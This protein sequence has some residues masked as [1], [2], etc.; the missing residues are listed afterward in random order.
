MKKNRKPP[1]S[2]GVDGEGQGRKS[3]RY[4]ML[5]YSDASG[6]RS[7][8]VEAKEGLSTVQC[9]DF[10]LS[11]P[12]SARAFAFAFNYDLTKILA[13]VPDRELYFL[14][15]PELRVRPLHPDW[16]PAPV[17]YFPDPEDH[18]CGYS[19][20]LQGTKF[21]VRRTRNAECKNPRSRTVWDV[22]RFFQ[23]SFVSALE[24]WKVGTDESRARMLRMKD[25]RKDFDKLPL[26]EIRPYCL[27]ECRDMATLA[28][29]LISAHAEAGIELK[30]FYGA[31]TTGGLILK[32]LSIDSHKRDV[33]PAMQEAVMVAFAGGRFEHSVFGPVE[34]PV[35]GW[36]IASAYPYQIYLLPC[37]NH[38]RWSYT[39]S[40]R[41]FE[42]ARHALVHYKLGKAPRGLA[43]GPFPFREPEG[44]IVFPVESGGGWVWREEYLAG[45]RIFPHVGFV[46]AWVLESDC[47]CHPFKRIAD[48]YKQRLAWGK[49]GKGIVL[50]LGC[51]SVNGKLC[52]SV[53][54]PPF[55][56]FA[57]SGMV[58]SGTRAQNLDMLGLHKRM[59]H[60]RAIATDGIYTS[61][62]IIPPRPLDTGTFDAIDADTGQP[63]PLGSWE[64]KSFP[65][66]MF[67]IRPGLYFPIGGGK[68]DLKEMRGRGIGRKAMARV[69]R[70]A[71][72]AYA[73]GE[74][75]IKLPSL[76]RFWGAKSTIGRVSRGDAMQGY[77]WEYRRTPDYGQWTK[78]PVALDFD[79]MPKRARIAADKQTLVVR[80]VKGESAPYDARVVS[81]EMRILREAEQEAIE[82]PFGG[83]G[84]DNLILYPE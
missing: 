68:A 79:P 84:S 3:H 30:K 77:D 43:W 38:A 60:L 31:G 45:E 59:A 47:R 67:F 22:F 54:K 18:E 83:D 44:S 33:P 40:R 28:D 55:Q 1:W 72:R 56:C 37:L 76:D 29:K 75:A 8:W 78:R 10:L 36:D 14:F 82:Q 16:G 61:E 62:S 63:K 27:S 17:S 13:D 81:P 48:Y 12:P 69:S 49:D 66:G 24:K 46:G 32:E 50:K 7:S 34:G 15:R 4:V 64:P 58:M 5:C 26:S 39:R 80:K 42:R 74:T 57:W 20:N 6:D 71:T 65:K 73:T 19:L 21:T 2:V 52:Q 35:E 41:R 23:S 51:N 53:G 70:L 25:K 11:I 9:L